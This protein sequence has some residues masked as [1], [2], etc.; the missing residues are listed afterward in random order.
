MVTTIPKSPHQYARE[1]DSESELQY[2]PSVLPK[3]NH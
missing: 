2:L 3:N 1:Y